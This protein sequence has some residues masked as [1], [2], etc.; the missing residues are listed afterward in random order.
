MNKDKS[1]KDLK[2]RNDQLTYQYRMRDI[3]CITLENRIEKYEEKIHN[4][5]NVIREL[6]DILTIKK[7]RMLNEPNYSQYYVEGYETAII[8]TH[9]SHSGIMLET[10]KHSTILLCDELLNKLTELKERYNVL[11]EDK[12]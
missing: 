9:S 8:V 11:F 12:N 4:L 1:I 5:T 6:E 10:A 2:K 3:R 7:A